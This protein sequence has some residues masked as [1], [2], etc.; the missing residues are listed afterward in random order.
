MQDRFITVKQAATM[1][2]IGKPAVYRWINEGLVPSFTD[3]KGRILLRLDDVLKPRI[4]K[5][6]KAIHRGKRGYQAALAPLK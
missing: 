1:L 5:S 2:S 3:P 4:G 6:P